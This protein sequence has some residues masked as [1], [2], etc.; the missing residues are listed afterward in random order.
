MSIKGVFTVRVSQSYKMAKPL[1][2][3]GCWGRRGVLG[4]KAC[5]V[6]SHFLALARLALHRHTSP[7]LTASPKATEPK[8]SL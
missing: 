8:G 5:S 3:E 7:C 2:G 4:G 6:C 1:R